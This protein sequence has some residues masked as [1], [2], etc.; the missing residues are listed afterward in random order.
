[1]RIF[2]SDIFDLPL[3][4]GHRFPMRKYSLLH[5]RVAAGALVPR[6]NLLVAPT[7]SREEIQRAHTA[8]YVKR[9]FAGELTAREQRVIGF[10]W[11]PNLVE[12]SC[13]SVGATIEACR[14]ALRD[15]VSVNL[16]GGTHHAYSDRG[17]GFCVFND[18]AVAARAVQAEGLARRI[19]VIDCDVH[20]GNGTA[21]IFADDP[22]VFTFSIHGANNFPFHKE[23]SDLDVALPDGAD[24][25]TYLEALHDGL[26]RLP[27]P[28]FDLVV[29]LAGADPFVG[30][31]L[32]RLAVSK[33]GLAERD[34]AVFQACRTAGLPVAVVMA[35]GYARHVEDIVD[36]HFATVQIASEFAGD[37]R[38]DALVTSYA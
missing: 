5:E 4:E 16:A 29:Y 8:A 14:S 26:R 10:P 35:G 15:G 31:T 1:M 27:L 28:E 21:A 2:Y 23:A 9:V 24:D 7:A 18:V 19:V 22:S 34:R 11:S 33:R 25:L 38:S 13:Q 36:I 32:G 17:Q 6:S 20:Q 37:Q 3:P 12:R 30:D